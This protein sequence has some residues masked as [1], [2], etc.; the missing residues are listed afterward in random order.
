M[1]KKL[2]NG[3]TNTK[4]ETNTTETTE[5]PITNNAPQDTLDTDIMDA[6]LEETA[7][8]EFIYKGVVY[9]EETF[10]Q[11]NPG[12]NKNNVKSVIANL[13]QKGLIATK[14]MPIKDKDIEKAIQETKVVY[15]AEVINED[16]EASNRYALETQRQDK[17]VYEHI[18]FDFPVARKAQ[19]F[20]LNVQNLCLQF[21]IRLETLNGENIYVVYAYNVPQKEANTLARI[22]KSD[23]FIAEASRRVN[24]F[25]NNAVSTVDYVSRNIV[26]PVSKS[27]FD[28][29]VKTGS[30]LLSGAAR[31]LACGVVAISKGIQQGAQ[32]MQQD[33]EI[34]A[35]RAEM[36]N[37][38]NTVIDMW[39]GGK[40]KGGNGIHIKY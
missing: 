31:I 29:T 24:N 6:L 27:A 5:T 8:E 12:L 2:G 18:A 17:L 22:Y 15:A 20:S 10:I 16:N 36:I 11:D 30:V 28:C 25:A 4:P 33:T 7:E 37:A 23:K 21:D 3:K 40:S 13:K 14:N 39:N 38:K 34:T 1:G 26:T 35:A 9:T 19:E 32:A